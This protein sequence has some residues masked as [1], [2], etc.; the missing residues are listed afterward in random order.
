[1]PESFRFSFPLHV[2]DTLFHRIPFKRAADGKRQVLKILA[3]ARAAE[4]L[5]AAARH[6]V[7]LG[8]GLG[9]GNW[10]SLSGPVLSAF[11]IH[12]AM[13]NIATR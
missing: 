4:N 8:L 10:P 6:L 5:H 7:L 1:M 2:K 11:M 9:I 13:R 12:C 3:M